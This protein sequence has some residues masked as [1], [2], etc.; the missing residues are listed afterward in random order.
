MT[1]RHD[2]LI[3]G[4]HCMPT[5]AG[6]TKAEQEARAKMLSK[7]AKKAWRTRRRM[8]AE[9]ETKPGRKASGRKAT[10]T[11]R[12][13]VAKTGRKV[14]AKKTSHQRTVEDSPYTVLGTKRLTPRQRSNAAKRAWAT[15]RENEAK[16]ARKARRKAPAS[17]TGRDEGAGA[18]A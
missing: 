8:A 7:R 12:H 18:N 16:E 9:T 5:T 6:L 10:K 17:R 11:G 3:E 13:A 2:H 15:R 1:A 4:D 14:A